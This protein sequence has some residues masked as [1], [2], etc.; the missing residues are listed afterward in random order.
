MAQNFNF[1]IEANTDRMTRKL[2]NFAQS[3]VRWAT[4]TTL[5]ETGKFLLKQNEKNMVRTFAKTNAYTRN[6]FYLKRANK[7]TLTAS[8]QRK[9]KPSGKHYLEVQKDGGARPRKAVET[10]MDL[11]LAYE[12]IIQSVTPTSRAGG[13]HNNILMSQV[14]KILAGTQGKGGV[15]YFYAGPFSL[16]KFGGGNKTGG[17]YRVSGKRGKPQKLFHF[18]D[19]AMK[20]RPKF[21]YFENMNRNAR[22]HFK[23]RFAANLRKAMR[24]SKFG[25][26]AG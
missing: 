3:Q 20:Y 6:A 1:R 24:T 7:K 18:H 2:T 25:M 26:T 15:R 8:I 9:D 4:V 22:I 11:N 19:R 13:K 12:G 17:V 14:N 5:N 10:K 21:N 16:T 23:M